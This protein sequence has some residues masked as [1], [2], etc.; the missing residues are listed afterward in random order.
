MQA[1]PFVALAVEP[2]AIVLHAANRRQQLLVTATLASG[3][4]VDVTREAE[5]SL[6]EAGVAR[7]ERDA[8]V[9]LRDGETELAVSAGGMS[10]K[11]PVRVRGFADYPS[12]HFA[13]DVVPIFSKLGCNSG[14]CHGRAS[15]QNGFKLSV[16]G[17]DPSADYDAIVKQARGRRVFP[18]SPSNSLILTKPSGR[19]PHGGGLRLA[20]NSL[21]YQL[22]YHWIEQGMPFGDETAPRLTGLKV[23]P[24]EREMSPGGEQQVLAT[25]F[26][27]DGSSRDVSS[28]A[29]YSSNAP[30]LAE[31]D[32]QGL[33][34]C[35][36]APGEAAITVNY[37]GQVA[38][39]Q[40]LLPRYGGPDPYPEIPIQNEIDPF[41]WSKLRKMGLL[42]SEPA[43]DATFLRRST[44][45]C[46]GT[47][48]TP[49]EVCEFLADTSPDKRSKWVDRLLARDEYADFW[50]LK[51][52]DILLVDREKLGDRG[53]F[54]LHRWLRDQFAANRPYD[55]WVRE[56]ITAA[57][58]S[59]KSGP[60]NLYRASDTPDALARMVSQAFLGVR[61]ECAQCHHHPFE[62]WSQRDYYG[63]AGFFQGIELKPLAKDRALVFHAGYREMPIPL[64]GQ[65]VS[66][67]ALDAEVSPR[68]VSED[69]RLVLA[70]W[71]TAPDNPWFARLA[72]NRLWKQFFG[73]GIVDPEDDLRSTNPPTNG[74]LLDFLAL[75]L[76]AAKFD[77]K[78]IMRL[79]MN[80]RAYQLS[81]E[82]NANNREDEQNFSHFYVK[83]MPA[84]AL[85][86]AICAVTEVA[87]NFP[88]RPMGTRAIS[89][90]DNR[91]PSYFLEIFGRPERTTPCECGRSSDP[92]MAQALHL[93]NAPEI[94]AKVSHPSGRVARLVESRA[95]EERIVEELCLITLGR[96][97]A[98]KHKATAR[99]LFASAP[100]REA[101][102]DF[103]WTLLNSYDFLFVR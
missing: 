33:I 43:D 84:E 1:V 62:K 12:V 89:L 55:E 10:L 27:S 56:L 26:Y 60:V 13:I 35:G 40:M 76:V 79:I 21:D 39:V 16:F 93:M 20:E 75:R 32:A 74:P 29:L 28:A 5:F 86:D 99:M 3:K 73:R 102:E 90:W 88:G 81:S 45:D 49:E 87:E 11:T 82:P 59:G 54:E 71:M 6:A 65:T 37:M 83:R 98:A 14:G 48:P 9:G 17:F 18:S 69:P 68:L 96:Y 91:L 70:D 36:H 24:L 80:S 94:E 4:R 57:G 64:T 100:P 92:T 31:A 66:A 23:S 42:P 72:V 19:E 51:W 47:L 15:G 25:A 8:I 58:D 7:F 77:L 101:A 38:A 50:A 78:A 22:L 52:A 41:V 97:P 44:V 95:S 85:L 34:R 2:A 67:R 30:H 53:A 63:L 46:L 61:I 103:L